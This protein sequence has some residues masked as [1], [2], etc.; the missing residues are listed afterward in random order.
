MEKEKEHVCV[1][2]CVCVCVRKRERE[3]T[4]E[5]KR[6]N[7]CVC[8]GKRGERGDHRTWLERVSAVPHEWVGTPGQGQGQAQ[9][10][11][12]VLVLVLVREGMLTLAQIGGGRRVGAHTVEED[13]QGLVHT[14]EE[15]VGEGPCIHG[16]DCDM[17]TPGQIFQKM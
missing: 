9:M 15:G 12:L 4:N 3:R 13:S 10:W 11:V 8:V 5:R 1:C 14:L 16:C 6:E 7:M 2:V 17:C